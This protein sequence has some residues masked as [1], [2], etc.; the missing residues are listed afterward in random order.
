[1][2]R[3]AEQHVLSLKPY[4]PG[5]SIEYDKKIA[6]WAK[7]GSNENC[8]G[9]SPCAIE[10]GINSLA[11]AHLYPNAR[12]FKI[13]EKICEHLKPFL[14]HPAQIALGNGTSELIVN[15]VRGVLGSNETLLFGWPSFIMYQ[16]AATAQGRNSIAVPLEADLSYDLKRM[17]HQAQRRKNNPVKIGHHC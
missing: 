8:F 3:L 2:L 17:V 11:V 16:L 15:L 1:M 10:S 13:V 6:A 7:L 4:V 5:R 14:V 9:P 12:R